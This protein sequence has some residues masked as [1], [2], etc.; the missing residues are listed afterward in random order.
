MEVTVVRYDQVVDLDILTF[1]LPSRE[2]LGRLLLAPSRLHFGYLGHLKLAHVRILLLL[3]LLLTYS[4][5]IG[6]RRLFGA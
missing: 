6:L 1:G 4:A 3:V 5:R 2:S